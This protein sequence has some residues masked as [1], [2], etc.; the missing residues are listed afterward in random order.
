[1]KKIFCIICGKYRKLKKHKIQRVFEKLLAFS[2]IFSNCS[3]EDKEIFKEEKS[4]KILKNLDLTV[5][6]EKYQN[7]YDWRERRSKFRL[8]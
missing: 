7:K 8:N 1:M 5:S 2:F 3:N 4:I 6:I